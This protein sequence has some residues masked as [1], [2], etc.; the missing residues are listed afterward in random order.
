MRIDPSYNVVKKPLRRQLYLDTATLQYMEGVRNSKSLMLYILIGV[1]ASKLINIGDKG[2]TFEMM[3]RTMTMML[4]LPLLSL[5]IL[6]ANVIFFVE[7]TIRVVMF[8]VLDEFVDWEEVS[9][10]QVDETAS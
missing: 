9:W 1:G 3:T 5:L 8:D 10:M 4:H 7:I 2:M 6:P